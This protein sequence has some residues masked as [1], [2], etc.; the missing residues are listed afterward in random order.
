MKALKKYWQ[1]SWFCWVTYVQVCGQSAT[2]SSAR[3]SFCAKT[4][5]LFINFL[6]LILSIAILWFPYFLTRRILEAFWS[7]RTR[8]LGMDLGF[9]A[10]IIIYRESVFWTYWFLQVSTTLMSLSS[11]CANISFLDPVWIMEHLRIEPGFYAI[12][13]C[14]KRT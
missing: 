12:S 5:S 11:Y 3:Y 2:S 13:Y 9:S 4:T 6:L 7:S 14:S 10:A 1:K 8:L